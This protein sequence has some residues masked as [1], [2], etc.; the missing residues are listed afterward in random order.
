[1]VQPAP[2]LLAT[3]TYFTMEGW[4]NTVGESSNINLFLTPSLT[5]LQDPLILLVYPKELIITPKAPALSNFTQD[6]YFTYLYIGNASLSQSILSFTS[7]VTNPSSIISLTLNSYLMYNET[8]FREHK[9][10][11]PTT[12]ILT[13]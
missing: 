3:S 2:S 4:G 10:L 13:P 6:E 12:L 7:S 11:S 1:M 9:E 5:L 8:H